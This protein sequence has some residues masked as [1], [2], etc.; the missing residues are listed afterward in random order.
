V[1]E[2]GGR[3]RGEQ[4]ELEGEIRRRSKRGRREEGEERGRY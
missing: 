4:G 3:G 1:N 2:G